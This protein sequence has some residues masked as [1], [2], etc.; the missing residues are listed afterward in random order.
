MNFTKNS[1]NFLYKLAPCEFKDFLYYFSLVVSYPIQNLLQC[2]KKKDAYPSYAN[3][4]RLSGLIL[5][6]NACSTV[7]ISLPTS[8]ENSFASLSLAIVEP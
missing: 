7:V 3:S 2:V 5:V 4:F 1:S 6:A 8:F